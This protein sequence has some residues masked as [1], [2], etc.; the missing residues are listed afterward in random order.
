MIEQLCSKL[1]PPIRKE[2]WRPLDALARVRAA[3]ADTPDRAAPAWIAPIASNADDWTTTGLIGDVDDD[4]N[5]FVVEA[6]VHKAAAALWGVRDAPWLGTTNRD[7]AAK[8]IVRRYYV[9]MRLPPPDGTVG[10]AE[11]DSLS[12]VEREKRLRGMGLS[13]RLA[14]HLLRAEIDAELANSKRA[15]RADEQALLT[16]AAAFRMIAKVAKP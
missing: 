1:L 16:A 9:A 3:F 15:A 2:R 6:A 11:Y 5:V 12:I 14:R 7:D 4:G 10:M 13:Q 8:D